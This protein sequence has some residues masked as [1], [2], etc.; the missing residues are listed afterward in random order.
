MDKAIKQKNLKAIRR[1]NV[2]ESLKDIGSGAASSI[3]SDLLERGSKDFLDQIFG[4]R[5][6]KKYSGE[7]SV[8]ESLEM[9]EVISGEYDEKKKLEGQLFLERQ[10]RQE[11]KI[12]VEKKGNELKLQLH[13]ITQEVIALALSTQDLGDELEVASVQAPTNPGV[14]H[15]VFFEKLLS[16]IKA[17]RKKI[18][19][20]SVWLHAS[21]NRAEKRSFWGRYKKHGSKF[22]LSPDHYLQRSAG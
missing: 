11:E 6:N 20:A 17:F 4:N 15:V 18:E 7:I 8:G 9:D 3:K 14:Y 19:N 13:A 2:L 22:L 10:L 1:Q 21:N 16:F 5:Q 12:L